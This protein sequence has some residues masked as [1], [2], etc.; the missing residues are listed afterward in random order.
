MVEVLAGFV[1]RKSNW[2][3]LVSAGGC[4]TSFSSFCCEMI[5]LNSDFV[6]LLCSCETGNASRSL[7]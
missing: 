3:K 2:R 4:D 5:F 6:R 1:F 7:R